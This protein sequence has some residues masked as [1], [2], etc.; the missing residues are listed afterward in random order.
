MSVARIL[1]F[2]GTT[3]ILLMFVAYKVNYCGMLME[4]VT[5]INTLIIIGFLLWRVI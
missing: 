4:Y 5:Q 3:C 2:S 1:L